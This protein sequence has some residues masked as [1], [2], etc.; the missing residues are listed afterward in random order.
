MAKIVQ[1]WICKGLF[2]FPAADKFHSRFTIKLRTLIRYHNLFDGAVLYYRLKR[3]QNFYGVL[4]AL[5]FSTKTFG[6]NVGVMMSGFFTGA[7]WRLTWPIG[8]NID[9]P[10]LTW[11]EW[12]GTP[13]ITLNIMTRAYHAKPQ[14]K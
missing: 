5:C 14:G 4:L 8:S 12:L 1:T 13:F 9:T 2:F 10:L 6:K 7:G 11:A 3:I